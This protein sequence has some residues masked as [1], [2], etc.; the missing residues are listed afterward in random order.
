MYGD[1]VHDRINDGHVVDGHFNCAK[2]PSVC[3]DGVLKK[4]RV[5]WDDHFKCDWVRRFGKTNN[6]AGGRPP[7]YK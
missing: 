6:L 5:N 4:K 7:Y 2:I 3:G 1:G